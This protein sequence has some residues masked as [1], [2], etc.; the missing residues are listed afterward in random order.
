[1]IIYPWKVVPIDLYLTPSYTNTKTR[2]RFKKK[3]FDFV[4]EKTLSGGAITIDFEVIFESMFNCD[5]V[6]KAT[7]QVIAKFETSK[8]KDND[9][10]WVELF[11][12]EVYSKIEKLLKDT[13]NIP[14]EMISAPTGLLLAGDI[15]ELT[16][17]VFEELTKQSF[18]Q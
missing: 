9:V 3:D 1:M 18:Y 17:R 8:I 11:W 14:L 15:S 10:V 2:C 4:I 6:V 12:A 13:N 16:A 5:L 7:F